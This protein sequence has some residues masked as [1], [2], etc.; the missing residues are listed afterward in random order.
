MILA[1]IIEIGEM[2][3]VDLF[4][5]TQHGFR[6]QRSTTT[7]ALELQTK[8][9]ELMDKGH[10]VAVASLDLSAAFDVI[11]IELLLKR[12][13]VMGIAPDVVDLTSAWLSDRSAYV[14]VNGECSA[15]FEVVCG[16]VQGSVLGPVLF[17]LFMS[18]FVN[19]ILL[20][21]L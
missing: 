5:K 15:Y 7:A 21:E 18:P 20:F 19:G 12:M 1:R 16:T 13:S 2:G 10:Y 9:A 8:I 6:K 4:G 17:N 3:K 14:E 11:N